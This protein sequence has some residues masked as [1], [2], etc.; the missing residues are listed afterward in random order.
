[1]AGKPV[2]T[3]GSMHVCPLCSGSVPHVGGPIIGPGMPGATINGQPIAVMGDM[4]TC[5]GPPDT[6]VQGCPGVTINGVPIAVVGSMTAH[7]GQITSGIPGVTIGTVVPEPDASM[8]LP[9]IPFP[10]ITILDDL[11]A[12]VVGKSK[13]HNTAKENIKEIK[14]DAS[15]T[16]REPI[17]H[18][19]K[20]EKEERLTKDSEVIKEVTFS[21]SVSNASEGESISFQAVRKNRDGSEEILDF[22]GKVENGKVYVKTEVEEKEQ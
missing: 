22:S 14:K 9:E 21:A 3:V 5:V 11:G 18:S 15:D 10:R 20:W 4:C 1:M 8:P 6:I 16:E 7:G 12:A 17:V 2:A 13:T 19:L